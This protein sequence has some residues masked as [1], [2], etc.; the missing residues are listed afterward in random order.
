MLDI[1][2]KIEYFIKIDLLLFFNGYQNI[3]NYIYNL[4]LAHIIFLLGSLGK[5]FHYFAIC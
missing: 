2:G 3:L 4:L 5:D 1:C